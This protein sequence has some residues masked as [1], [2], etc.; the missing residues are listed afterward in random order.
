MRFD[1]SQGVVLLE[2]DLGGSRQARLV[3][4]TGN[5]LTVLDLDAARELG[6]PLQESDKKTQGSGAK[7]FTYFQI[8]PS[9]FRL[10][11]TDLP[12][13]VVV[14]SVR[15][16]FQLAGVN[17][18]GALGYGALKDRVVQIDYPARRIR[19]LD[20]GATKLAAERGQTFS[21]T[22]KKYWSGSPNLVTVDD[23]Q[24]A[25][26]RLCAQ[27]DTFYQATAILF[28]TKLPWL[29]T[30]PATDA[31]PVRYEDAELSPARV[32]DGLALGN[33]RLDG[34]APVYIAG[35]DAHVPETDL[36]VVLGTG[37]FRQRVLTL[38]Y[39]ASRLI[40]E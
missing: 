32:P 28:S 35:A 8:T 4:D 14:T 27:V 26:H 6:L 36:S 2:A 3:L 25:G 15:K 10:G 23:V 7:I 16:D 40:I 5:P 39:P 34:N 9:K 17:C 30:E 13:K 1:F 20:A 24:I 37:F 29:K 33:L 11:E 21:I 19:F 12:G 38:D 22:W 18:D 31:K